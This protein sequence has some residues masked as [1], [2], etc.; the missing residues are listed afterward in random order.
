MTSSSNPKLIELREM[1]RT[2]DKHFTPWLCKEENLANLSQ[3]I[4]ID[5]EFE[6]REKKVGTYYL[7]I[8]CKNRKDKSPVAIENQFGPSD[9]AHLGQILTY[10]VGL[11]IATMIWI[12]EDFTDLHR[13]AI[14]W[15]NKN[16]PEEFSFF[17]VKAEAKRIDSLNPVFEFV[18]FSIVCKPDG[19]KIKKYH[20]KNQ[21]NKEKKSRDQDSGLFYWQEFQKYLEGKKSKL[22]HLNPID[23]NWQRLSISVSCMYIDARINK[24]RTKISV[25]L[26]LEHPT[27]SKTYFEHLEKD[28][29]A[30]EKEIGVGVKLEWRNSPKN[31]GAT[32]IQVKEV[33]PKNWKKQHAWLKER[34]ETFEKVFKERM[35][36]IAE[37]VKN[38]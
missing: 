2:E 38:N 12:A 26:N 23:R 17:A 25:E 20:R 11:D 32:I 29:K 5:L 13:K 14:K 36:D 9:H 33:D 3:K 22:S 30:I 34:M 24:P 6:D 19:H 4:G 16:T 18:D 27:L 15:L 10:G 31:K 1:F 35:Q 28:K 21:A 8:L 7:D 37:E